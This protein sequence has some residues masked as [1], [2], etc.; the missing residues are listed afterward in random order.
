LEQISENFLSSELSIVIMDVL[1]TVIFDA[2]GGWDINTFD[3]SDSPLST[4]VKPA[5]GP[6]L[7]L[8]CI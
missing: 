7:T 5:I 4:G 3:I 6:D 1:D 2:E 8:A